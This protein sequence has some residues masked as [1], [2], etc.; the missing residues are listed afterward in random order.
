MAMAGWD[1]VT[2]AAISLDRVIDLAQSHLDA[3]DG[4]IA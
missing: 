1:V 3:I 4:G 2:K